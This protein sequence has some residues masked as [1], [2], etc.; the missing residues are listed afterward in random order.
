MSWSWLTKPNLRMNCMLSKLTR[1]LD[2]ER[3]VEP[4]WNTKQNTV[5]PAFWQITGHLRGRK[6]WPFAMTLM[7]I[8]ASDWLEVPS[9]QNSYWNWPFRVGFPMK[10]GIRPAVDVKSCTT[11]AWNP[12]NNRI[13]T[14][15]QLV[16]DFATIL[17]MFP[18]CSHNKL[19]FHV[20]QSV[21]PEFRPFFSWGVGRNTVWMG[22][23]WL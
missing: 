4:S 21:P 22:N 23:D 12:I 10:N 19:V 17:S 15:Y 20:L 14:I 13:F 11:T 3:I 6:T 2:L 16:Q 9:C 7:A 18:G 5:S 8:S 1:W